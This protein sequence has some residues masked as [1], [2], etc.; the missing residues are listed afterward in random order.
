MS[1]ELEEIKSY[2]KITWDDED[3]DIQLIIDRGK[4]RLKGLSGVE[5]DFETEGLARELLFEYC[6]YAYNNAVEYFEENFQQE[7][8]R[9]QLQTGVNEYIT[10]LAELN[11]EGVILE[12]EFE[13]TITGY[14]AETDNE[15]SN[16]EAV[17]RTPEANISIEIN[18]ETFENDTEYSWETG[19]NTV[20]ITVENDGNN[21]VYTVV[22]T[23]EN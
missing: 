15:T 23:Y 16:I 18:G 9:L 4:S 3:S 19:E 1:E 5:L 12:P 17:P 20:E 14:T 21:Q 11:I 8:L 13:P 7:I 10:T 6:R 2:L 22:V